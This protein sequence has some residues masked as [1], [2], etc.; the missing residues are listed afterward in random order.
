MLSL[1]KYI[2][3]F[4]PVLSTGWARTIQ[5]NTDRVLMAPIIEI[6][7]LDR[8]APLSLGFFSDKEWALAGPIEEVEDPDV[9]HDPDG[10]P[11]TADPLNLVI[12]I[13]QGTRNGSGLFEE[14]EDPDVIHDPDGQ[15]RTADSLNLVILIR[16]GTRDGSGFFEEVEDPDVIHD[17]DGQPRTASPFNLVLLIRQGTRDDSDFFEE[18]EDPDVIHDP[19]GQP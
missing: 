2:C 13:R 7:V 1:F 15:P 11:R 10:Q 8:G 16:Q 17:P 6:E 14:V 4:L 12:L 3:V 18:V 5:L 19:D 9:I